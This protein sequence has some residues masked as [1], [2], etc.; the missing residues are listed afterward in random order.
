MQTILSSCPV[1]GSYS[2]L[3]VLA[4]KSSYLHVEFNMTDFETNAI[5]YVLTKLLNVLFCQERY[6][7]LKYCKVSIKV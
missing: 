5:G 7:K 1:T 3:L 6:P 2:S 4:C